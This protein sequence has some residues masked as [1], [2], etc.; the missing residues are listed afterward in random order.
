MFSTESLDATGRLVLLEVV[1]HGPLSRA[2]LTRRLDLSAPTVTRACR[3]LLEGG[4]V[5]EGGPS[6]VVSPGRPS[7]PLSVRPSAACFLGV[8]LTSSAAHL[9]LLDLGGGVLATQTR[10]EASDSREG[11]QAAVTGWLRELA[12]SGHHP[13]GIG[14]SL[15]TTVD[16]AGLASR[17]AFL[18]WDPADL[19]AL[20]S[21]AVGLPCVVDNDVNALTVAEHWF[22]HGRGVRD[23]GVVTVGIGTGIGVVANDQLVRGH[24]G[25][26]GQL[27][28]LSSHRGDAMSLL[29]ESWPLARRAAKLTGRDVSP[30]TL[31]EVMDDPRLEGLWRE[32]AVALGELVGMF[33]LFLAPERVLVSGENARLVAPHLPDLW[34]GFETVTA[35]RGVGP[36]LEVRELD[37]NQWA[38]GAA[39][40]A[41]RAVLLGSSD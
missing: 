39:A 16:E 29:L 22:G 33:V 32:M 41:I 19:G 31:V 14:I 15:A 28:D 38:R 20:V 30:Q 34:W 35:R 21:S 23:F 13:S 27:G 24:R 37:A 40:L 17:S 12:G 9:A 5:Q 26:A 6:A 2:D 36:D 18:R 10:A 1:R 25:T 8:N 11:L 4:L 7:H 3:G